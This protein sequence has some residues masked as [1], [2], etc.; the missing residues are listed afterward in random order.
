MMTSLLQG[1]LIETTA[2]WLLTFTLHS[3]VLLAT[4]WVLTKALK[5]RLGSFEETAWKAALVMGFFTATVQIGFEI[6]PLHWRI[7]NTQP[8]AQEHAG[9]IERQAFQAPFNLVPAVT[10]EAPPPTSEQTASPASSPTKA[11]SPFPWLEAFAIFW[12]LGGLFFLT[13]L[14]ANLLRLHKI[15][16]NRRPLRTG[17]LYQKLRAL[18]RQ[19][20]FTRSVHLS[21]SPNLQIPIA[22]GLWRAEICVPERA[23]KQLSPSQQTSMLAHELAHLHFRDPIW[24]RFM[25]FL[26]AIFFFQPLLRIANRHLCNLAELR[27][28]DWAVHRVGHP[29]D[30]AHCLTEVAGWTLKQPPLPV[31]GITKGEPI[32]RKR[33]QRLLN[34][35]TPN[36]R[37]PTWLGRALIICSLGMVA[38]AAPAILPTDPVGATSPMVASATNAT[39]ADAEAI[40]PATAT[41]S[42]TVTSASQPELAS[43][44][45]ETTVASVALAP[46][47]ASAETVASKTT[48]AVSSVISTV[49]GNQAIQA[50]IASASSMKQTYNYYKT[51]GDQY[52][53]IRELTIT[54]PEELIVDGGRNGG[55]SIKGWNKPEVHIVAKVMVYSKYE[56]KAEEHFENIQVIAGD[57][58]YAEGPSDHHWGVSFEIFAPSNIDVDLETYNGGISLSNLNGNLRFKA[59]NGGIRLSN[60][61]GNVF[62]RTTNGGLNVDLEGSSWN[63]EALDVET[64]NG[65]IILAMPEDYNTELKTGTVNGRLDF[66]FPITVQGEINKKFHTVLGKGGPPVRLVTTNGSVVIKKF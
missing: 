7:Q 21:E 32:L 63:G 60:L 3:T 59:L 29:H 11:S 5:T 2:S 8:V 24:L 47:I 25:H 17:P 41:I 23:G 4:V 49:T 45:A 62:G 53:E 18:K 65:G 40:S 13:R 28:D 16:R 52:E 43:G 27:C 61:A 22:F 9:P 50:T 20:K 56:D 35:K 38:M 55:I 14:T 30:L 42:S 48:T 10:D 64:T 44:T 51:N 19:S 34:S 12:L 26:E 6:N 36:H 15:L 31:P 39:I 1:N 66:R 33:I 54:A 58:I 37:G 57:R 46:E